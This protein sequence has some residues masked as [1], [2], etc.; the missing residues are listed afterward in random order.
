MRPLALAL[1]FV[2]GADVPAKP[3]RTLRLDYYHTGNTT[4][5][6]FAVD[7]I[8][9]EPAPWMGNS[10][11]P[12]DTLN[13]GNYLFEVADAATKR[14]L[15]SRGFNSIYAEWVTTAEAKTAT[16]TFHESL[17]FAMPEAPVQVAVKK[18]DGQNA[19]REVWTTTVDPQNKFIDRAVPEALGPLAIETNGDPSAKVDL[20]LMGDGYTAAEKAKF[21]A[22]ARRLMGQLWAT[23]PFR[24]RR[25]DFNVW[26]LCPP[27]RE[28]GISRPSD[29]IYRAAPLGTTYD[30]FGSER[31]VL[32]FDNRTLRQAAA[33]VPYDFL[34]ILANSRTYGGGGIFGQYATVTVDSVW[35][36]YIF[37]HEFGH[38]F[39]GLADEYFTAPVAYLPAA[40]R[41]EPWEPN[42]TIQSERAALKW[43]DLINPDTPL[44]TPW[45]KEDYESRSREYQR[46]REQ[47]RKERR[48]EAEFDALSRDY[49]ILDDRL[50][51]MEKHLGKVGAFEGANYEAKGYYR[52]EVNCIMFTRSDAFCEVCRRAL[53]RVIDQY[54]K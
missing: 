22:D 27:A 3:P 44:P 52:S 32:T 9:V 15:Y 42:V 38:H 10:R 48:P 26:G 8:V 54:T 37:V 30:A 1:L 43:K 29:E 31:Y 51:G 7:R 24:E 46:R 33:V 19:W 20:L 18:R 40:R 45:N 14:V 50:L 41:V 35:A 25:R 21:E 34:V 16:R 12:L 39:A 4:Q 17:R 6:L 2:F 11:Q 36:P 13:L 5:E 53:S 23:P 28:S 49:K 47:L